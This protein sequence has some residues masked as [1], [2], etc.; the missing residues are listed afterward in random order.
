MFLLSLKEFGPSLLL[1]ISFFFVSYMPL[2]LIEG[3][4]MFNNTIFLLLDLSKRL[5]AGDIVGGLSV[6]FFVILSPIAPSF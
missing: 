4:A 6:T 1:Y 2:G 3:Q 5:R